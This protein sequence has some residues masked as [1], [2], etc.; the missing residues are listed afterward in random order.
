M[1]TG[2]YLLYF[3]EIS[4]V[5]VGQSINIEKRYR[6]HISALKLQKHTNY[7]LQ[8]VYQLYGI[9]KL[10]ILEICS[11]NE[12]DKLEIHWTDEFNSIESGLNISVPGKGAASGPANHNSKYSVL[13][14]LRVFRALYLTS[15]SDIEISDK[16]KVNVATI[17]AIR[18][19]H[20]HRWLEDKYPK[21]Y[22]KIRSYITNRT[23]TPKNL[24]PGGSYLRDP[25]GNVHHIQNIRR[26][27]YEHGLD[28]SAISKVQLGKKSSVKGWTAVNK[29]Q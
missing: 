1:T 11:L 22:A 15:I 27:A 21:Q 5:Y 25:E 8:E 10:Q 28:S 19:G 26:F 2:I 18:L 4:E 9:P 12:L 13:Q 17:R 20:S 23:Y 6:D 3:D 24:I 14:I 7:K 29:L 16:Y